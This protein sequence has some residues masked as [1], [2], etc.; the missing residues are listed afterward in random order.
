MKRIFYYSILIFIFSCFI[1][2]FY[3]RLWKNNNESLATENITG[4]ANT[5][6]E[7]VSNEEK[8]SFNSNFAIKKYYDECG[9]NETSFAELPNELVNLS[10]TELANLFPDWEVEEF[11]SNSVIL[12]KRENTICNEHYVL[13]MNDDEVDVFHIEKDRR[14][15]DVYS[16]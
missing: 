3:A 5:V 2:F 16:Y 6:T 4:E 13:K 8:I 11:S 15:E 14:R 9:H 10:K 7:T 1:G 12:S